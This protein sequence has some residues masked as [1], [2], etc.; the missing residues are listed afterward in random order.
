MRRA[1]AAAITVTLSAAAAPPA[2]AAIFETDDRVAADVAGVRQLPVARVN[3]SGT[4]TGSGFLVGECHLLT[5]AHV[6]ARGPALGRRVTVRLAGDR[7][8]GTVVAAGHGARGWDYRGDWALVALDHCLGRAHVPLPVAAA[9]AGAELIAAGFP[10]RGARL[11]VDP[12]CTVHSAA[13]GQLHH[14]CAALPGNS[15]G[16]LLRRDPVSGALAVVAL[17]VAGHHGARPE[18][19]RPE[20]ANLAIALSAL[21]PLIRPYLDGWRARL[22]SNQRPH[23]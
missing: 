9:E 13:D 6:I 20:R 16:P 5:A 19:F 4:L 3:G 15:G 2:G 14:D 12:R 1:A 17:N 18:P 22:D 7:T 10:A 8:N 11:L 21:W 23:A